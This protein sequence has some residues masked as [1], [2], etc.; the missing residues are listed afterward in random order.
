MQ[1]RRDICHML[2]ALAAARCGDARGQTASLRL[3]RSDMM[4]IDLPVVVIGQS[5]TYALKNG[6]EA[7]IKSGVFAENSAKFSF[8][9]TYDFADYFKGGGVAVEFMEKFDRNSHFVSMFGG[10][11]HNIFGLIEHPIKFDFFCDNSTVNS[12]DVGRTIIPYQLMKLHFRKTLD[13]FPLH[14]MKQ[15]KEYFT[16]KNI[17]LSSPP[18]IA[19]EDC[20]RKTT[21][22]FRDKLAN[23]IA[24]ISLRKKLYDLHSDVVSS[25]CREIGFTYIYPPNEAVDA[26]GMLLEKHWD[27]STHA[28]PSYGQILHRQVLE[29]LSS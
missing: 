27:D 8:I 5:H 6:I 17:H 24:P 12:I 19:S 10:Q 4:K 13:V 9:N 11:L 23:G 18:L 15:L 28:A 7:N 16:G 22:Y 14:A 21:V 29:A 1:T 25:A 2:G 20:I 3:T 26:S